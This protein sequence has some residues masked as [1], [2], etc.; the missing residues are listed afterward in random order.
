[1]I[2]MYIDAEEG[3]NAAFGAEDEDTASGKLT[4]IVLSKS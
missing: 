2:Y 1:M 4:F 3:Q